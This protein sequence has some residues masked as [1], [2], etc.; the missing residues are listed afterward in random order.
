MS[1]E[2]TYTTGNTPKFKNGYIDRVQLGGYP[3]DGATIGQQG[4]VEGGLYFAIHEVAV[5]V[6][7][8]AVSGEIIS[9]V[10]VGQAQPQRL[11][12]I[13]FPGGTGQFV[14]FFGGAIVFVNLLATLR[15]LLSS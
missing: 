15:N 13:G 2:T 14:G 10:V 3:P 6:P 1:V 7:F 5:V 8:N 12:G 4:G 9:A 11:K